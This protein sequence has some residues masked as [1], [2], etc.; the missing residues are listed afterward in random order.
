[1]GRSSV[2]EGCGNKERTGPRETCGLGTTGTLRCDGCGEESRQETR[3]P[4]R[5]AGLR[6]EH[7]RYPVR[8]RRT[9]SLCCVIRGSSAANIGVNGYSPLLQQ[10]FRNVATVFVALTP[11][12]QFFRGYTSPFSQSE[13]LDLLFERSRNSWNGLRRLSP[14]R[15]SGRTSPG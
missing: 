8:T 11:L 9:P 2:D 4:N 13:I 1:M 12:P 5:T 14:V 6:D 10:P 15:I 3:R 7:M